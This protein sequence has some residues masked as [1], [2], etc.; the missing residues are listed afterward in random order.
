VDPTDVTTSDN[1]CD[2]TMSH[3][4]VSTETQHESESDQLPGHDVNEPQTSSEPRRSSRQPKK[5][6]R[7][8]EW[9]E[10]S[11]LH[12]VAKAMNNERRQH[13]LYFVDVCEPKTIDEAL[14]TP[15][16]EEWK[17]AANEEM[18]AIEAMNAWKLVPLPEGKKPVGC[19]W[20]FKVKY[21]PNEQLKDSQPD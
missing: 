2:D 3:P 16:A 5:P 7:Y 12:S 14:R 10:E 21:K 4:T 17:K 18:Q 6:D 8:G 9:V 15:E 13:Y 11:K 19:K 1:M 20:V